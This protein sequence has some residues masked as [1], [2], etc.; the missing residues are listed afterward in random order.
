MYFL[1]PRARRARRAHVA[2]RVQQHDA[3][4]AQQIVHLGEELRVVVDA[5]VLEHADRYDAV[6]LLPY[7]AVVAQLE[8]YPVGQPRLARPLVRQ[9]V[10]LLGQRDAGDIDLLEACEIERELAPAAADVEHLEAGLEVEL[11]GDQAQLVLLGLL[12]RFGVVEEVGAGILHPLVEEELV[13]VVAEVVV[14]RHV[15]LRLA[16][17][18][19]LLEALEAARDAAQHLLQGLVAERKP[20]Q[21]EQ[22]E[23]VAQRR[24]LEA[25]APVHVGLAGRKLWIEEQLAVERG[26]G[27]PH[28]DLRARRAGE[29]V[30]LALRIDD[31]ERADAHEGFEH[32]RQGKHGLLPQMPLR[33]PR[34]SAERRLVEAP[35]LA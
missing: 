8:A 9:L 5:D 26:V 3:V 19:R 18:V 33:R 34:P 28:G 16:D 27:E 23:E 17:R 24:I 30:G 21:R 20:V 22:R 14:V 15:L 11:G 2:D 7:L 4:L 35:E 29:D 31:L 1:Q 10:L 25:H 32:V 6:E 12:Q 13:E